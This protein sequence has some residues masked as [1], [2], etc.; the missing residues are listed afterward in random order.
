[1]T[2]FMSA[3]HASKSEK[4]MLVLYKEYTCTSMK[5]KKKTRKENEKKMKENGRNNEKN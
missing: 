4:N 5:L 3:K 2:N 1:M